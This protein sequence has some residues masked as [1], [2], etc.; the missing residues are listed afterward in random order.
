ME[1]ARE[2][3]DYW[4]EPLV[5]LNANFKRAESVQ[6]LA[7]RGVLE[8]A[9]ADI[10]VPPQRARIHGGPCQKLV[11]NITTTAMP[12]TAV[13]AQPKKRWRRLMV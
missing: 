1:A 9:C 11:P 10:R 13:A 6:S 5:Q 3:G 12:I 2:R 8:P 4:P 7:S